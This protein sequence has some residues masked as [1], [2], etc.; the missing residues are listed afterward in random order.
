MLEPVEDIQRHIRRVRFRDRP[1]QS[2]YFGNGEGKMSCFDPK[3]PS[4]LG[5]KKSESQALL[6]T[7]ET[8]ADDKFKFVPTIQLNS[9]N[10]GKL[11]LENKK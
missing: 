6:A 9:G 10:Q 2:Q 8:V 11:V 1:I 5:L 3:L 7:N 4:A